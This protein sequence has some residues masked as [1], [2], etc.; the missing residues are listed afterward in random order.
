MTNVTYPSMLQKR[1]YISMKTVKVTE[2]QDELVIQS[3]IYEQARSRENRDS[4]AQKKTLLFEVRP[5]ESVL[6]EF[7]LISSPKRQGISCSELSTSFSS[8]L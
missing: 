1:T 5:P 7:P 2:T 8:P 6:I 3:L 4:M